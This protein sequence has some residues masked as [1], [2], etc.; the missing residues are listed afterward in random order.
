MDQVTV[1]VQH[2]THRYLFH[3]LRLVQIYMKINCSDD[4]TA[5]LNTLHTQAM[6]R[7][8][9]EKALGRVYKNSTTEVAPAQPLQLEP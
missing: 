8:L 4:V 5:R 2:H 1:E 6:K 3:A 9:F 7:L